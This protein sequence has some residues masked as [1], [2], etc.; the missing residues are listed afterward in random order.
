[1]LTSF[2]GEKDVRA[3]LREVFDKPKIPVNAKMVA[4]PLTDHYALVGNAFDYLFR[5]YL[6]RLN[7]NAETGTWIAEKA[8]SHMEL[9]ASVSMRPGFSQQSRERTMRLT[10]AA[11]DMVSSAKQHYSEYLD[12]GEIT[13][14]LLGSTLRLAQLEP[15]GRRGYR[16]YDVKGIGQTD[17][18]DVENLRALIGAVDDSLF[19]SESVC[20]LNPHFGA[21]L[22][23]G[24]A[25]VDLVIDDM[26]IDVKTT[27]YSALR[28]CDFNQLIGYY[29][30]HL[31]RGSVCSDG[32]PYTGAINR[33][34]IYFS[35]HGH[36]LLMDVYEITKNVDLPRF[37]R[38]FVRRAANGGLAARLVDGCYELRATSRLRRRSPLHLLLDAPDT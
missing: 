13:D 30:L 22:L 33:L 24:G 25:D 7:P 17:A 27:K 3:K 31:L 12:S 34:G 6:K 28:R 38:W 37:I 21:S 36:L 11:R 1:M 2:I 32:S 15:I 18:K 10:T 26:M 23:V 19:R 9:M 4:P 35:R 8:L 5:F 29:V 20:L 14:A 16:G